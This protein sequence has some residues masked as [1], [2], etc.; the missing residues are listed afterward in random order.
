MISPPSFCGATFRDDKMK[1][2]GAA[3]FASL[4]MAAPAAAADLFGS[5][6]PLSFPASQAATA[7]EV[8]SNW[9]VRGDL[10]IGFNNAPT[11]SLSTLPSLP[12]GLLGFGSASNGSNVGF[13]GGLGFGYRINDFLRLDATWDY[14]DAPGWTRSFAAVCPYGLVGVADPITNAPVGY[15]YDT[16]NTCAGSAHLR[17]YNNTALANTYVDLGTYSG[18]TP[19]VGGGLG[20]NANSLQGSTSF[21]E[22]A[23]GLPY[24]ANLASN[25]RLSLNVG[26]SKR[27]GD[28]S[29][30]DGPVRPAELEPYDQ[31]DE[32]P[33][34][35][36]G[37]G[38]NLLPAYPERDARRRLPLP[39]R[40]PVKPPSQSANQPYRE[41]E[42]RLATNPRRDPLRAAVNGKTL[43]AA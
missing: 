1:L 21:V 17:Q 8:G 14:W 7:I 39:R 28:Q 26:Q 40:W 37:D 15:L 33:F 10:G 24:V 41:A 25:R 3:A 30:A 16:T 31:F 11:I 34:R 19:Y 38:R 5:A 20:L 43:R 23:N 22:T 13:V 36:G 32:L 4:A 18:F 2:I 42:Q 29:P 6:P 9:Y 35:L 27:R 12:T